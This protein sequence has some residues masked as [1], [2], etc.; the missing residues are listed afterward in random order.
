MSTAANAYW[1]EVT[2]KIQNRKMKRKIICFDKV[3]LREFA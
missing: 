1:C 3:C 2:A